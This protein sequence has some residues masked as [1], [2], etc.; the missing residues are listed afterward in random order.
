MQTDGF[1]PKGQ[2]LVILLAICGPT[3]VAPFRD[4]SNALF[5]KEMPRGK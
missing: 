4:L 2:S 3:E 1:S 5:R